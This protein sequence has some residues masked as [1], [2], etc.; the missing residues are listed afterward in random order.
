MSCAASHLA[1]YLL[2]METKQVTLLLLENGDI[3][4]GRLVPAGSNQRSVCLCVQTL[5]VS[6]SELLAASDL[7]QVLLFLFFFSDIMAVT[8][9]DSATVSGVY[10]LRVTQKKAVFPV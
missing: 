2:P 7:P 3:S 10:L 8:F 1:A 5:T 6:H 9:S 4:T